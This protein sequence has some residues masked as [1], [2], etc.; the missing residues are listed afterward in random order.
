MRGQLIL[1]GLQRWWHLSWA[2]MVGLR[3]FRSSGDSRKP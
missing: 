1:K 3:I 2:M